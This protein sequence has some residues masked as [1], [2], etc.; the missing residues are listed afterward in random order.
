MTKAAF[1]HHDF[2]KVYTDSMPPG[3]HAFIDAGRNCEDIAMQY[4]VSNRTALPP[5]YVRGYM[6][7]LGV[8]GGI[9]TS[10]N[11]VSAAHMDARSN[12]L[13]QLSKLFRGTPLVYSKTIV[14]SAANGW[15]NAPSTWS[16][17]ISSDLWN[18]L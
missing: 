1:I 7:D 8:L 6:T 18:F 9:S 2:F 13:T 17:Y 10:R 14:A 4:L 16:E 3:V 5:I 11:I 15:I 12:C